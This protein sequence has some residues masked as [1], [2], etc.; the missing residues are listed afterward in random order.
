[1]GF[2]DDLFTPVGGLVDSPG[3]P[4]VPAVWSCMLLLGTPALPRRSPETEIGA[5][6]S[7]RRHLWTLPEKNMGSH[8]LRG[9]CGE[10]WFGAVQLS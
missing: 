2:A 4:Y 6:P 1:M 3:C 8:R 5:T 9:T 10:T 7:P